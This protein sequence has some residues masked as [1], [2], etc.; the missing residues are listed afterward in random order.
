MV[1]LDGHMTPSGQ[2]ISGHVPDLFMCTDF[3]V[4]RPAELVG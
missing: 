2:K 4:W 3:E 1:G